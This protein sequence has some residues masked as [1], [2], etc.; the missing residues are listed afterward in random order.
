MFAFWDYNLITTLHHHFS[1]S[2]PL[3]TSLCSSSNC[4]LLFINCCCLWNDPNFRYVFSPE[5]IQSLIE[6]LGIG[7]MDYLNSRAEK[8]CMSALCC[9]PVGNELRSRPK[10]K[11]ISMRYPFSAMTQ[12]LDLTLN[13][14]EILENS[15]HVSNHFWECQFLFVMGKRTCF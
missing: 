11:C 6:S 4:F 8:Q 2:K 9:L 15:E 14:M 12:N 10:W 5:M 13:V 7:K 1:L 3:H